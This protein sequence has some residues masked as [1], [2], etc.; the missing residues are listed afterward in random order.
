MIHH[1]HNAVTL[2]VN[3]GLW[4]V[5]DKQYF[6]LT[7]RL[8]ETNCNYDYLYTAMWNCIAKQTFGVLMAD[9]GVCRESRRS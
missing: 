4:E 5:D 6:K 7:R 9:E 1:N 8:K 2:E 3:F